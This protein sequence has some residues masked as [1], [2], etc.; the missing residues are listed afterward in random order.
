MKTE[1][2]M[3][4]ASFGTK[5]FADLKNFVASHMKI[6]LYAI[7]MDTAEI[8]DVGISTQKPNPN[9]LHLLLLPLLILF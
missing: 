5:A 7:M 3:E 4:L 1:R 8:T 9:L 6:F 2:E